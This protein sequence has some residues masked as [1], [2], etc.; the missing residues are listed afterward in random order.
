LAK[1]SFTDRQRQD[2]YEWLETTDP[3]PLHHQAK[4]LYEPGTGEWV[5]RSSDWTNWIGRKA[6]C[7]WIHGIPGAGKTVLASYL[8][9]QVKSHCVESKSPQVTHAYYYCY[10]GHNQD[11]AAPFLRW[12][13]CRLCRQSG[14]V[15]VEVHRLYKRGGQPSLEELLDAFESVAKQ[16]ATI[17]IVVDALDESSSRIR[18]LR[19]LNDFVNDRRFWMIQL[20]ATSRRHI[21]IENVMS[22]SSVPIS[23]SNPLV[24]NDIR[25]Q[26]RSTL[27]SHPKFKRWPVHL[28][29]EVEDAVAIGA[30]GMYVVSAAIFP[31]ALI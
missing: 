29:S 8:I 4:E 16:F 25:L 10:H 11:E 21:D 13:I 12:I 5:L 27:R 31:K 30:K 18:L 23:M 9:E 19:A 22:G 1:T 6:R 2:I 3:S 14:T 20:L 17:Y 28:L 24:E 15:P 26:A 7:L